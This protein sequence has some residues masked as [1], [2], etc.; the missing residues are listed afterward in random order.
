MRL[1][2]A[3]DEDMS[4]MALHVAAASGNDIVA[5]ALLVAR[6][7]FIFTFIFS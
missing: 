3:P 1:G 2:Q 4:L 7:G 6:A 5:T